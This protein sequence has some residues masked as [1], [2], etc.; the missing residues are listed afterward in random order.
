MYTGNGYPLK[1][2]IV[3]KIVESHI[4]IRCPATGR[5]EW[6]W[7]RYIPGTTLFE[8]VGCDNSNGST[9]CTRCKT[10]TVAKL[11]ET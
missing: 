1:E 9:T 5:T 10:E 6:M 11:K 8:C 2:V 7:Y 3:N 4:E